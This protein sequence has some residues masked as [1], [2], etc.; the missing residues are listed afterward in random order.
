MSFIIALYVREGIVM[1]SDSR[2]MLSAKRMQG[3]TEVVQMG[4][5]L[6]D[7]TYKTFLTLNNI[8]IS[9]FGAPEVQGVPISG[10]IES[11]IHEEVY[12]NELEVDEIPEALLDYFKRIEVMPDSGFLVAGYKPGEDIYIGIDAASSEFY[13]EG[14]YELASEG[15]SLTSE[16][17]ID[18][19]ASWV[20]KYPILSI[21]D[22]MD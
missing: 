16:E 15:K 7:S 9:F 21:E 20:D 14:K 12:A 13:K 2:L 4:V 1:A 17:F 6:S 19:L 3:E 18:V 10:Y 5:G 11:F 8:G 22:G